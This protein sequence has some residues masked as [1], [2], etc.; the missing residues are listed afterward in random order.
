[1]RKYMY[2][3][4]NVYIHT[5]IHVHSCRSYVKK[6]PCMHV[7]VC[8]CRG[9]HLLRQ[10]QSTTPEHISAEDLAHGSI[11]HARA[12]MQV[13][14]SRHGGCC[15]KKNLSDAQSLSSSTQTCSL[16]LET[17]KVDAASA[18][19]PPPGLPLTDW[20]VAAAAATSAVAVEASPALT[21]P[22]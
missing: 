5:I 10:R 1:M 7:C 9:T 18:A 13:H 6:M 16:L 19:T 4:K 11:T 15:P 21:P 20:L 12:H 17:G 2:L 8:V 14:T 22:G 3:Y